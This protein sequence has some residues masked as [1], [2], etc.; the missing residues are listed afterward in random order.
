MAFLA[1]CELGSARLPECVPPSTAASPCSRCSCSTLAGGCG[2]HPGSTGG[3]AGGTTTDGGTGTDG[4]T[5]TD[6]GTGTDGGTDGGVTAA[7]AACLARSQAIRT[8]P[9]KIIE[10]SPAA[11]G[12]VNVAGGGTKTLRAVV[13]SEASEGDTILLEDGTYTIAEA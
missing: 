13:K 12:M 4:G 10:V 1:V 3:D 9:G 5:T 8:K 11:G 6:G 7:E 2:G